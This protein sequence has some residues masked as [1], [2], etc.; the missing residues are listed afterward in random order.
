MTLEVDRNR[1]GQCPNELLA[2]SIMRVNVKIGI[3]QLVGVLNGESE[4]EPIIGGVDRLRGDAIVSQ[5]SVDG[6]RS[7]RRRPDMI[8]DLEKWR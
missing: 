4:F 6:I 8:H 7:F 2:T 1:I 5:P 3:E